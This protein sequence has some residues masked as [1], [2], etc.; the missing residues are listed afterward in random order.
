MRGFIDQLISW[1][2]RGACLVIFL[3]LSFLDSPSVAE[4]QYLANEE[5]SSHPD[6]G[7]VR[8]AEEAQLQSEMQQLLQMQK[9]AVESL[10]SLGNFLPSLEDMMDYIRQDQLEDRSFAE[11]QIKEL[12]SKS[13]QVISLIEQQKFLRAKIIA[14][15]I[16]WSD[17]GDYEIDE[18]NTKK[19]DEIREA[20]LEEIK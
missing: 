11:K 7:D 16:M 6:Q 8:S 18:Q 20:L 5:I 14:M 2:I 3:S 17:V 9:S 15:S 19:Y 4:D 12:D 1:Q 13:L 10:N